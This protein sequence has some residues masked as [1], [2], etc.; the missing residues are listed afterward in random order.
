M[1]KL[2]WDA[3]GERTYET[4]TKNGVLYPLAND[5]TYPQGYAWNGLTSV[6]ESP[7]G[8]EANAVYADDI[9]YVELRSAEDYGATIEALSYPPEWE[10]CDGSREV[11]PGVVI[12]QQD[13]KP[14]GFVYKSVKGNDSKKNEYGYKIH[15]LYNGTA[16]TSERQYQT[17]NES[18]ETIT[19]SWEVTT[20]PIPVLS[21]GGTVMTDANGNEYKPTSHLVI[22]STK[23]TTTAEK[24]RLAALETILFGGEGTSAVANLPLPGA[25]IEALQAPSGATGTT[26]GA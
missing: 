23:F 10:D 21:T 11:A 15:I 13:R 4:G 1:P 24:A 7:S 19:F 22:D 25:I 6:T 2:T 20:T 14:F 9:K 16:S 5:G 3:V 17:V 8:A 26:T 18:P 12:G